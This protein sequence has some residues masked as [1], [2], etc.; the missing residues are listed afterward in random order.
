MTPSLPPSSSHVPYSASQPP[1]PHHPPTHPPPACLPACLPVPAD[2]WSMP[3]LIQVF[4]AVVSLIVFVSMAAC[5]CMAE[6][7]LN[8][9]TRNLMA[10]GHSK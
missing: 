1:P 2:C 5:F 7:D 8:P 4:V 9:T 10:M 6:M 3:H